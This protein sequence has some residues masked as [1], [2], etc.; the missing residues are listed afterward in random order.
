MFSIERLIATKRFYREKIPYNSLVC[1]S[2]V[3]ILT[4]LYLPSAYFSGVLTN[5]TSHCE[6]LTNDEDQKFAQ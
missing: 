6:F 2:M 5:N 3:L 1:L 4:V